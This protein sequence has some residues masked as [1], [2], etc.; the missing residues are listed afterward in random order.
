MQKGNYAGTGSYGG[1]WNYWT[2]KV[3]V[4]GG[5]GAVLLVTYGVVLSHVLDKYF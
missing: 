3:A 4:Y 1:Y 2:K 5:I